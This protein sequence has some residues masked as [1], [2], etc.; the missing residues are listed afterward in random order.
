VVPV[1][2]GFTSIS[3]YVQGVEGAA[4]TVSFEISAPGFTP[5]TARHTVVQPQLDVAGLL[6]GITTLSPDDVFTVRVGLGNGVNLTALQ[7]IRAGGTPLTATIVTDSVAVARLVTATDTGAVVTVQ[8]P[9]LA[10]SSPGSVA[11]GG[12]AQE[13]LTAGV[14]V[15]RAS[16]PGVLTTTTGGNRTVTVTA[17]GITSSA[18]TVGAGLQE[19]WSATLGASDHGGVDVV[20]RSTNPQVALVAPNSTTP[21][22]ESIVV[23]VANGFTSISYYVQG[24][25]GAADTVSFEISAPSFTPATARHT[26]VQPQLDVAGLLTGITTLSLDDVFTV[27]VGLGNG[28]NLTALQEIR[29]G[30]TALTATV[31]SSVPTVGQLVTNTLT[32]G[33]VT[34][35]I[36]VLASSSPGTVA[37]GGVA[38]D[39][40]TAGVTTLSAAIPGFVTT[41]SGGIREVTV[42]TPA[43]T[44]TAVTV[45]AGLQENASVNLGANDYGATTVIIKSSNPA[46]AL[47]SPNATT[48]GSDSIM[49]P[50]TSPTTSASFY[51][52]GLEGQT[53]TVTISARAAGFTDGSNT[54]TVVQPALDI[55]GL[56]QT[57][58]AGAAD[59][60][61]TVRVGTGTS[62]AL[63]VLQEARAGGPGLTVTVTSSAPTFGQLVTQADTSGTVTV[64]VA[65]G[66]STTPTT[67]A[68]GGVAFDALAAGAT[69]VSASIPGFVTTANG[70]RPVT[71]N[72]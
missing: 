40:L 3:Y 45:G 20:I 69:T 38:H 63:S 41:T 57:T 44:V 19:N 18:T 14:T 59:D 1:A 15:V 24:V 5:A 70:V 29:A 51:V 7:E 64:T 43:I 13:P 35:Q 48:A 47:V 56:L 27:R 39:P 23:P 6:T 46:V 28:V 17:P 58:T 12:V 49:I 16:I 62:S 2:N 65:A 33:T 66:A 53:G 8:I 54:A 22:T 68:A 67:V 10:S 72:P 31:T 30:G 9:V 71:I 60:P 32:S 4:D 55:T 50:F 34:V 26:V 36:P 37:A 42:T 11:A 21:G 25:E 61:F 52:H